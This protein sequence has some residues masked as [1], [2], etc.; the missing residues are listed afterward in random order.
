MSSFDA[1]IRSGSTGS[2]HADLSEATQ[3]A[4]GPPRSSKSVFADPGNDLM[5]AGLGGAFLGGF[6]TQFT[7]AHKYYGEAISNYNAR[8]AA[9]RPA[10]T[11]DDLQPGLDGSLSKESSDVFLRFK[12]AMSAPLEPLTDVAK[13]G[14]MD[15]AM[16]DAIR[17]ALAGGAIGLAAGLGVGA[18]V[19]YLDRHHLL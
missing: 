9:P 1:D 2:N 3:S 12:M 8:L 17:P 16:I 15:D 5:I 7:L 4:Y 13:S 11:L 19:W 6:G 14:I 10:L 18:L